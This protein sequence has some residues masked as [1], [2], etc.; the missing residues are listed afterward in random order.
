MGKDVPITTKRKFEVIIVTDNFAHT[1][2][3]KFQG[4][5]QEL[6]KTRSSHPSRIERFILF[7]CEYFQYGNRK[8]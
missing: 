2:M 6:S 4:A 7:V 5:S 1:H 3:G 8:F